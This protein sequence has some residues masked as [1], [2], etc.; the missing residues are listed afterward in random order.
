MS[1][2]IPSQQVS[3]AV[4]KLA[5]DYPMGEYIPA[6][7]AFRAFAQENDIIA[8]IIVGSESWKFAKPAGILDIGTGDG[9]V[10]RSCLDLVDVLPD[11]VRVLEPNDIL[12]VEAR[13]ALKKFK[14]KID[15]EFIG[16][17]IAEKLPGI[18]DCVD[19]AIISH[20]LYLLPMAL[21][22]DIINALPENVP[23]I[24]ITDAQNSLFSQCWNITAPKYSRR[25]ENIHEIVGGFDKTNHTVSANKFYTYLRNPFTLERQD[26]KYK[27]LSLVCYAGFDS[28]SDAK[29]QKIESLFKMHSVENETDIIKCQSVCYEVTKLK[30]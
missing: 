25:A 26:I 18:F 14:P 16:S 20:V 30:A 12:M 6:W 5:L 13:S 17:G 2:I 23:L 9:L 11:K 29:K 1:T 15:F 4:S 28:L 21:V 3:Q 19:L 7:K 22:E 10:L 27:I 24:I 8:K